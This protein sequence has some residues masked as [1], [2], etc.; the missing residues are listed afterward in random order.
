MFAYSI[1]L[2]HSFTKRLVA[3]LLYLELRYKLG[4]LKKKRVKDIHVSC[5][6]GVYDIVLETRFAIIIQLK[7]IMVTQ[8]F[9]GKKFTEF[10]NS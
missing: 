8:K 6:S 7:K 5:P 1:T 4:I 2:F 10:K 9:S 3:T